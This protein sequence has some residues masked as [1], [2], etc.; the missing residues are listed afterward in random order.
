MAI[1]EFV[2]G[3]KK[4]D[5]EGEIKITAYECRLDRK[6]CA[7]A[8]YDGMKLL[9]WEHCS[10]YQG[11]LDGENFDFVNCKIPNSVKFIYEKD[12]RPSL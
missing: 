5:V 3:N 8:K 11:F 12:T 7:F 1:G 2:K 10:Y 6:L 4:N 9:K